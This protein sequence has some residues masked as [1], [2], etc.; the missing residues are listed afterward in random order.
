MMDATEQHR[1]QCEV[2]WCLRQGADWF[3]SYIQAVKQERGVEAARRLWEDVKQQHALGNRG[4]PGCWMEQ[5]TAR[6]DGC[7]HSIGL[8]RQAAAVRVNAQADAL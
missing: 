1:H 3:R 7:P 6:E 4:E 8:S 5:Q 2:R